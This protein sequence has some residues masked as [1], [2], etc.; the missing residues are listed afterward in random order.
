[1][2]GTP[3]QPLGKVA[4]L[5]RRP[6]IIDPAATY[7]QIAARS[8]GKGTFHQPPLLGSEITWQK[9]YL[10]K[11]GDILI[12]N[13]KAW[14]GAVAVVAPED[15]G[16]FGSHR[17]LTCVPIENIVVAEF[18]C[19]YLLSQEGLRRLGEAS[20][21]S[22]DRNRTL[23]TQ[24]LLKIP[25]PVPPIETQRRIVARIED[26]AG[27]ISEVKSLRSQAMKEFDALH[28]SI[29]ASLFQAEG[30]SASPLGEVVGRENFRNGK[31]PKV[32]TANDAVRCLRLSSLQAG[33]ID[34]SDSKPVEISLAEARAFFIH[35]GD[36]FVMRGNGSKDLV[37]RAGY[38]K[39]TAPT[40]IFP[41]LLIKVPL[42]REVLLPEFFVAYWNSPK[43]RQRIEDVA[44]TGAGIW[45]IN[46]A[47][48]ASLPV[49]VPPIRD[50]EKVVRRIAEF[51]EL[52]TSSWREHTEIA[53][54]LDALLPSILE[55]AFRGEL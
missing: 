53:P 43:M 7:P 12:S 25:I 5:Q 36:V 1:M 6:V 55:R 50:Q 23:N 17:Y 42:K 13:I 41:D 26:L 18:V 31:S 19:F 35:A 48:L 9:P 16:R 54:K 14:E 51:S 11:A 46:Q 34:V 24:G 44:K 3:R 2:Q 32:A 40:T 21:G 15:D 4:P 20:P 8:F 22:A 10:V 45:K 49:P 28:S 38:A 27:R 33:L 52:L 47:H 39:Q 30:W 29:H 37:G